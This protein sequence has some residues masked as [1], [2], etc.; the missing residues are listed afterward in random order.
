MYAEERKYRFAVTLAV[1]GMFTL[2]MPGVSFSQAPFYKGKT[3]RLIEARRPGGTG[4][5]R[6]RSIIP[7][8][9]KYI[10]GNPTIAL[11]YI[12]G[13]GGRKAA[14]YLYK[15]ARPDG[16][17]ISNLSSSTIPLGVLKA[18]GVEY[19]VFKFGHLGTF[20]SKRRSIFYSMKA[21]GLK[22][23]EELRAKKGVRIGGQSVGFPNY[24]RSRFLAWLVGLNEP[25][26]VAGYSNPEMYA[27]LLR[28][29]LDARTG[30][31]DSLLVERPDWVK[32]GLVDFHVMMEVPI[33]NTHPDFPNV[34][35]IGAFANTDKERR[36]L[37]MFRSF[38]VL[39]QP[40]VAPPGVPKDRLE[41]LQKAFRKAYSDP[42][43]RRNY[44]KL[45][46]ADP[47]PL[48]PEDVDKVIRDLPRDTGLIKLYKKIAGGGPLPPR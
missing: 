19:D 17:T 35:E 47:S 12:P 10:P 45:T 13:G 24:I 42:E 5:M 33:G 9:R 11:E 32:K 23:M 40:T 43:F 2:G 22:T 36:V 4:D 25:R 27:A 20:Y 29:E 30:N 46:G 21:A 15:A 44:R 28:G 8:L 7:L 26:F 31:L 18:L 6:V 48:M 41:I 3:L 38:Q 39:G 1:L 37:S 34:K 14:N 16:L